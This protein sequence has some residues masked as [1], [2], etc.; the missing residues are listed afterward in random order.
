[1]TNSA[2]WLLFS[3]TSTRIFQNRIELALE[4]AP[5]NLKTLVKN[6]S[7]NEQYRSKTVQ[8]DAI[9]VFVENMKRKI[10]SEVKKSRYFTI[11]ADEASDISNKEQMSLVIYNII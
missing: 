5:K 6:A 10:V 8:N 4:F 9:Q 7:G 11:L 3:V 1:M 2:L